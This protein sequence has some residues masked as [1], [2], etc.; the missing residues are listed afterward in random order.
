M[1]GILSVWTN[2]LVGWKPKYF[3]LH[4]C[5]LIF[6][7]HKGGQK[8][9]SIHLKIAT[10]SSTPDDPLRIII[11]TG[12]SEM[13]LKAGSLQEKISWTNALKD[14]HEEAKQKDLRKKQDSLTNGS[15]L[16]TKSRMLADTKSNMFNDRLSQLASLQTEFDESL[17]LFV[18]K[19][20]KINGLKE[21]AGKLESIG[22]DMKQRVSV[23][24]NEI[25]DEKASLL[26]VIDYLES[27]KGGRENLHP[28]D[29]LINY[30]KY[31]EQLNG[32]KSY[33]TPM[34]NSPNYDVNYNGGGQDADDEDNESFYSF[35]VEDG[36]LHMPGMQE[37]E[38]EEK[39]NGG[40]MG[41]GGHQGGN[42]FFYYF[43]LKEI[44]LQGIIEG[45]ATQVLHSTSSA[46]LFQGIIS[47]EPA[48][49]LVA[50]IQLSR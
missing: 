25:E 31:E 9:G 6:C 33:G 3:I 14:A 4:D 38:E 17:K 30:D 13:H 40:R 5:A 7:D 49:R 12:T 32:R 28:Q 42:V 44:V 2:V 15:S 10:I 1:E 24:I 29:R 18:Q 37:D 47:A 22:V 50:T 11:N 16:A 46:L 20:A 39:I 48:E 34:R 23:C 41:G 8:K 45:K 26:T 19:V 36:Y 35:A 27:K 43:F 21:L